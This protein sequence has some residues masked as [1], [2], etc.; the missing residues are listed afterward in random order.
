MQEYYLQKVIYIIKSFYYNRVESRYL[1]S[2][3]NVLDII[4]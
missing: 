2:I 3:I 1:C 4:L